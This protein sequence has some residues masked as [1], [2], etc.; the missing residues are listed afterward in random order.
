VSVNGET[1][2][3]VGGIGQ[4]TYRLNSGKIPNNS[5]VVISGV[6]T[7]VNGL[8]SRPTVNFTAEGILNSNNDHNQRDNNT[9]EYN[10]TN[11]TINGN[12]ATVEDNLV[13]IY[14][15]SSTKEINRTVN[16]YKAQANIYK[17]TRINSYNVSGDVANINNIPYIVVKYFKEKDRTVYNL[18]GDATRDIYRNFYIVNYNA[19]RTVRSIETTYKQNYTVIETTNI[20]HYTV[21]T[22]GYY[23]VAQTNK[24]NDSDTTTVLVPNTGVYDKKTYDYTYILVLIGTVII[25]LFTGLRLKNN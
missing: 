5:K 21:T 7:Y 8:F 24:T 14:S 4:N 22:E 17:K 15:A 10:I 12:S 6:I 1:L 20:P 2:R 16:R 25:G 19:V 3:S 23:D 11:V 18:I 9:F 13:D